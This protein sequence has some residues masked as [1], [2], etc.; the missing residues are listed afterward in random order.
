MSVVVHVQG[1]WFGNIVLPA[2]PG[3]PEIL[4]VPP[5][6]SGGNAPAGGGGGGAPPAGGGGGAPAQ[7]TPTPLP[8]GGSSGDDDDDDTSGSEDDYCWPRAPGSPCGK[9]RLRATGS[10]QPGPGL[11]VEEPR[12]LK[13]SRNIVFRQAVVHNF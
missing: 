12:P 9:W 10:S 1:D 4:Y 5:A 8:A 13:R 11:P 3:L 6:P 7:R 2:L